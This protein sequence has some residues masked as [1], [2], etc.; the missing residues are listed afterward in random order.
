MSNSF[1]NLRHGR[2][3]T[4]I[5]SSVISLGAVI[6]IAVII[7]IIATVIAIVIVVS[8]TV[9]VSMVP[10]PPKSPTRI[11]VPAGKC[12]AVSATAAALAA[13]N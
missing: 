6:G 9:D 5:V 12:S 10:H 7:V 3:H 2:E 1:R 4:V 13:P 11:K 8:T